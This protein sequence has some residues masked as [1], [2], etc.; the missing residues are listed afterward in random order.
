M[1]LYHP[2]LRVHP[3]YAC[4]FIM[5]I[6]RATRHQARA[7]GHKVGTSIFRALL[8]R[9][10]KN[11]HV[12]KKR[13][14]IYTWYIFPSPQERGGVTVDI[15]YLQISAF[16]RIYWYYRTGSKNTYNTLKSATR[17]GQERK[18]AP[19]EGVGNPFQGGEGPFVFCSTRRAWNPSSYV[20][21]SPHCLSYPD[22][23]SKGDKRGG[24]I[25]VRPRRSHLHRADAVVTFVSSCCGWVLL[26]S[27]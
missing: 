21:D 24:C 16:T 5:T 25:A 10:C 14:E 7:R 23:F 17:D 18:G 3:R 2:G 6:Q 26:S 12:K 20:S 9:H 22:S 15:G 13:E 1:I 8:Q 11:K 19:P 27:A 4:R